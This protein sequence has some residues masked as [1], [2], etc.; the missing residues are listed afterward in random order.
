MYLKW[1]P[2]TAASDVRV[3]NH[4]SQ[5]KDIFMEAMARVFMKS[6]ETKV[7]QGCFQRSITEF[8]GFSSR[9]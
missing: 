7:R 2:S 6:L 8:Q 3:V 4:R 5:Q 9:A 1:K